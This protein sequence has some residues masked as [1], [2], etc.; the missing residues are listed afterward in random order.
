MDTKIQK[1][2]I[3]TGFGFPV[4]LRNVL[5]VKARDEWTPKI[6]YNDLADAVMRALAFKPSRLTGSEIKFIRTHFD[7]TLQAFATRLCV[8]HVAVLKWEGAKA[9]PTVMSWSTEKDIRLFILSKL[10]VKAVLIAKLYSALESKPEAKSQ[11][12]D[13]NEEDLAA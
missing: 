2:F 6:N 12:L 10:Q 13:L 5:M 8:T 9:H 11:P 1:E 7:M 3:D 4:K